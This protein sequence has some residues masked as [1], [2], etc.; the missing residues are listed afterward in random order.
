MRDI[1]TINVFQGA[2]TVVKN[3]AETS[4]AFRLRMPAQN[5]VFSIE[6]LI[7]GDGTV[8]LSYTVCSTK[9]G[10]YFT[11]TNATSIVAG[12]TKT[13]GS[14]GAGI[15]G[16]SFTPPMFPWMKIVATETGTSNNAVVTLK[17]NIQ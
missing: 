13:S 7:T 9:T 11:P 4:D 1:T 10:T 14:G 16:I 15:G 17:L 5:G 6:Y 8:T 2:K 3:T 12:I